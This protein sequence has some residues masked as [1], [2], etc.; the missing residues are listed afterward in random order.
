MSGHEHTGFAMIPMWLVCD[1]RVT[2]AALRVFAVLAGHVHE[3]GTWRLT[4]EEIGRDS[5]Y[6]RSSVIAALNLLRQIGVV[7]WE[8]PDLKDPDQTLGCVYWVKVDRH[9]V[10]TPRPPEETPRIQPSEHPVSSR[11]NTNIDSPQTHT[12]GPPTLALVGLPAE[13]PKRKVARTIP[14]D[15]RPNARHAAYAREHDLDLPTIAFAFRANA[16]ASGKT[17]KDW[18]AAFRN[19]LANEV[20]YAARRPGRLAVGS[21]VR[22]DGNGRIREDY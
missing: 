18:D 22:R 10:N 14:D 11:V 7:D 8:T 19:W 3:Q 2:P 1:E 17:W 13:K 15:W 20:I 16:E 6:K 4:H 9:G 5:G 21:P 12:E